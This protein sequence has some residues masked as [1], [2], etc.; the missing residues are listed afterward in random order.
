MTLIAMLCVPVP[1][2]PPYIPI[3]S[4]S[5][6]LLHL[7]LCVKQA[8]YPD[9]GPI[10]IVPEELLADSHAVPQAT[11]RPIYSTMHEATVAAWLEIGEKYGYGSAVWLPGGLWDH[12][13]LMAGGF[14][15]LG[16]REPFIMIPEAWNLSPYQVGVLQNVLARLERGGIIQ[17][18]MG[19]LNPNTLALGG[20]YGREV[21]ILWHPSGRI[22]IV[23]GSHSECPKPPGYEDWLYISHTHLEQLPSWDSMYHDLAFLGKTPGVIELVVGSEGSV[24]I[25]AHPLIRFR[26]P[27]IIR[28][29]FHPR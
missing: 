9:R 8:L 22:V 14:T 27:S 17:A 7:G 24:F 16:H 1:N 25:L 2:H 15:C 3:P 6:E 10:I 18:R 12:Y 19:E 20:I 5:E 13:W 21:G 26:P 29:P 11:I 23:M 4:L 28:S